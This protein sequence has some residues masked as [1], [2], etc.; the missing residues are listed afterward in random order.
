MG[1]NINNAIIKTVQW[2]EKEGILVDFLK[3][4]GGTIMG[5][6]E[7]EFSYENFEKII[8][9]D[10]RED[11]IKDVIKKM[12]MDGIPI[13]RISRIMEIPVNEIEKICEV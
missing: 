3:K 10:A 6:L 1:E 4:Y 12:K 13:A 2:C 9:E 7:Q 11:T 5:V 8:R